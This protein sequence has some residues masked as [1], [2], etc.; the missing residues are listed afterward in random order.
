MAVEDILRRILKDSQNKR[1]EILDKARE[2]REKIIQEAKKVAERVFNET[3]LK[4][5]NE[6]RQEAQRQII[7]ERLESRKVLLS[8]RRKILDDVFKRINDIP[9][10]KKIKK[11]IIMPDKEREEDLE[12]EKY[13][14][15]IRPKLEPEVS[16]I[17]WPE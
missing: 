1:K 12:I 10:S 4:K 3:I 7:L 5:E 14:E 8:F 15:E 16:K 11:K 13:L 6:A 17:L 2:E 9:L